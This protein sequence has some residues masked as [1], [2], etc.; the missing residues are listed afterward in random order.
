VVV[1]AHPSSF[2]REEQ[3]RKKLLE[4]LENGSPA[5]R[6]VLVEDEFL[7]PKHWLI[8]WAVSRNTLV[9]QEPA[10][11]MEVLMHAYRLPKLWELPRWIQA[12]AKKLGGTIEPNAAVRLSEMVGEDTRIAAQELGKLLIHA[13]YERPV[14]LADVEQVSINSAP[15]NIF[16]LVDALGTKNGKEAQHVLHQLLE[17]VDAGEIWGMVIRQFRLLL[18]AREMLDVGAGTGEIQ[19]VLHLHE[20][21]AQKVSGQ[22]RQFSIRHLESIY[23]RL[24]EIDEQ[25]KTSQVPLDLALD[26]FIVELTGI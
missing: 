2:F 19:K 22:A 25:A 12:E 7:D 20:F 9:K 18:Q 16:K 1:M 8:K 26:T 24:L 10:A 4:M 11:G 14:T 6:L 15:G 13:N 21:V 3:T 23:H 5:T 17:E